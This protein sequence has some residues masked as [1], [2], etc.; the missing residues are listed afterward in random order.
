MTRHYDWTTGDKKGRLL[1]KGI[2][3]AAK[4][5]FS[6]D[7]PNTVAQLLNAISSACRAKAALA[8]LKELEEVRERLDELEQIAGIARKGRIMQ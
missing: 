1:R 8:E 5:M 2:N 4:L 7:N 6:S 3:H